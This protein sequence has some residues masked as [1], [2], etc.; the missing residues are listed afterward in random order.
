MASQQ[1]TTFGD[2]LKQAL[3]DAGQK[4][5]WLARELPADASQVSRWIN[6]KSR[7]V[8]EML[9]SI[10]ELLGVDLSEAYQRSL[11]ADE[12]SMPKYDLF[13]STPIYGLQ[14]AEI[15][16]HR[17]DVA[18]VVAAGEK[19][20]GRVYWSGEEVKSWHDRGAADLA[21]ET[22]L[23]ALA[24]CRAYLYVQFAPMEYPS[25]AL[26][27][28]GIA[29]GRKLKT[30]MIIK[31]DLRRP[32]MFQGFAGVAEKLEFLPETHVYDVNDADEAVR[33]IEHDGPQLL[34]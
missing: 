6:G 28:L 15:Q 16:A 14:D 24:R 1:D 2:A 18:K 20:V 10:N 5:A 9:H 32:Y 33:L 17:D 13:V 7:P 22:S 25:G 27:E 21:T 29:L 34:L 3:V 23:R 11:L 19:V 31:K 30:T 8:P 4:P 12:R 26:V